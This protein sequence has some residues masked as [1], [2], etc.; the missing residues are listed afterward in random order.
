MNAQLTPAPILQRNNLRANE[1]YVYQTSV[2]NPAITS[3][4]NGGWTWGGLVIFDYVGG[5]FRPLIYY[6]YE[7][8]QQDYAWSV[9]QE[10][11][12]GMPSPWFHVHVETCLRPTL[13]WVPP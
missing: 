5:V 7:I 12:N 8:Y 2:M 6:W 1:S 13:T 11:M 3:N 4:P 9:Q 10:G